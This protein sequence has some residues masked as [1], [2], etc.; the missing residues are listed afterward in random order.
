MTEGH[1]S[2]AG[3]LESQIMFRLKRLQFLEDIGINPF[4]AEPPLRTAANSVI[5]ENADDF[6]QNGESVHAVGRVKRISRHKEKTFITLDDGSGELDKTRGD[7]QL[8][9]SKDTHSELYDI[10]SYGIDEGDFLHATG[11]LFTTTK[12]GELTINVTDFDILAKAIRPPLNRRK[13]DEINPDVA[14]GQRY[15]DLMSS[16]EVIERFRIR[17]R[18]VQIMRDTFIRLG[19][20]EV[21]TPMM[22]TTYGGASARTF[23]THHNALNQDMFLRI[24]DELYLKRLIV[25]MLNDGAG[26][27]FEF[28]RDFR[29]EGMDAIHHPEFTQVELYMPYKD[30]NF[31]MDMTEKLYK[32]ILDKIRGELQIEFQG[33]VINFDNW[34]KVRIFDGLKDVLNIDPLTISDEDLNSLVEE[35]GINPNIG[36]GFKLVELFE[37]AVIPHYGPDPIFVLDY[38]VETS[39]L[40]KIHRSE[41]DLAERFE[42]YVNGMELANCYTELN[43]SRDQRRRFIEETKRRLAGDAEAQPEDEDFIIAMEHGLP[44]MGGIGLSIDRLVMLL[45]NRPHIQDV[46]LFPHRRK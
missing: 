33:K 7:L 1:I 24:S 41:S 13:G 19:N 45:T 30:Y 32:E 42:L 35:Y 6:I 25:G 37:E 5:R 44:P 9:V 17:S 39:P 12:K 8:L 28:S 16:P 27:V 31:M 18:I 26:G 34:R 38:P 14:R 10:L 22:D 3:S 46:I 40:T 4:P 15:L 2:S 43:D 21:E 23:T 11:P 36:R 29:N 20:L